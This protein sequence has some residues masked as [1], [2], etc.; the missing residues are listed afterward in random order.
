MNPPFGAQ[1]GHWVRK[2][3]AEAGNGAT[4]VCLIPSRT[5]TSWWHECVKDAEVRF[6]RGRIKFVGAKHNAPFPAAV[7]IFRGRA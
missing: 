3:H 7:V 5:D 4:V 1:I 2:A 6:I